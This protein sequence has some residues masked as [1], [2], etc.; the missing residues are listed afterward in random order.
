[1]VAPPAVWYVPARV[2]RPNNEPNGRR[3]FD[4][5]ACSDT[6]QSMGS[7]TRQQ[8]APYNRI[9]RVRGRTRRLLRWLAIGCCC[10]VLAYG[11]TAAQAQR[12]IPGAGIEGSGI[13]I[14]R[15]SIE[16]AI[17]HYGPGYRIARAYLANAE[18][19]YDSLGIGFGYRPYNRLHTIEEILLV[20]PCR[21]TVFGHIGIGS[22]MDQALRID[23]CALS[24]SYDDN[25]RCDCPGIRMLATADS[26]RSQNPGTQRIH[27]IILHDADRNGACRSCPYQHD[28]RPYAA[29]LMAVKAL[30][31]TP[32]IDT[33]NFARRLANTLR[34]CDSLAGGGEWDVGDRWPANILAAQRMLPAGA[35]V[36]DCVLAMPE[37]RL[38][39]RLL[40]INGMVVAG[41]IADPSNTHIHADTIQA[42]IV[43]DTAAANQFVQRHRQL[44]GGS[45]TLSS[46]ITSPFARQVVGTYC[47]LG[48]QRTYM[49]RQLRAGVVARD[50]FL[51]RTWLAAMTPEIQTY[52]ALGLLV[53]QRR[54]MRLAPADL[55]AIQRLREVTTPMLTCSGCL[56][57]S[58][59]PPSTQLGDT[60]VLIFDEMAKER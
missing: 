4:Q 49:A 39:L 9:A 36:Q 34:H 5:I 20:Q 52:G 43:S 16:D 19:W 33:G 46:G 56:L 51:F 6:V 31:A 37:S 10:A 42:V 15:S 59:S 38:G 7:S 29:L 1:M 8:P 48:G 21:A 23:G 45:A 30:L 50:T 12:A 3:L 44:W 57:S 2:G 13:S 25:I 60:F 55:A 47:A 18:L 35:S 40:I 53:L 24:A 26:N 28:N 54:G 17:A 14:G 32:G 58:D 11:G 41:A 27:T 22:H